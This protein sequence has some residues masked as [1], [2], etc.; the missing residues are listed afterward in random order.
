MIDLTKGCNKCGNR[1]LVNFTEDNIKFTRCVKCGNVERI[2]EPKK[3]YKKE[4]KKKI[5]GH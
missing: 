2:I 1:G 3:I 5:N 4:R